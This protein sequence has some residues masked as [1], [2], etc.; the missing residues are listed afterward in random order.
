MES[1]FA[2]PKKWHLDCV[3][4]IN[5]VWRAKYGQEKQEVVLKLRGDSGNSL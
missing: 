5:L 3:C 2:K 4:G 1:L